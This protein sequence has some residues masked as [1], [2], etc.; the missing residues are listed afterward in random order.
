MRGSADSSRG[1]AGAVGGTARPVE[2]QS[3]ECWFPEAFF[4]R[5]GRLLGP[6]AD[7]FL[8]AL[9]APP[10]G[11]RVNTLRLSPDRFLAL[12]PF[13]LAP[14]PFPPEGFEVLGGPRPGRHPYHAA[15][16]YYLQDPSAMAVAALV[17]PQPGEWI[18]DLAAAPGGK[19]THLAARLSGEGVLVANDVHRGRARELAGNL[20]RFGVRNAVVTA[21]RTERLVEYFGAVFD[22]VL[23]DAPCSGEAMFSKSEAAR[24]E[25]SP[26]AIAGCAR[27]QLDLLH[28]AAALVWPG[29]RLVYATCTFAPEE[30]EEVIARFLDADPDF[31]LEA[32]DGIPGAMPG[33]PDWVRS[34]LR[35]EDLTKAVRLWP[36]RF[37][38]AGHFIAGLR[39]VGGAGS[40]RGRDRRGGAGRA[41]P[42]PGREQLSLLEAYA[43]ETLAADEGAGSWVERLGPD[44]LVTLGPE[45][46][47]L[48]EGVSFPAGL[49][50]VRP[51]WWLG[52]LRKGRFEPSH[53]LALA[54]RSE[55]VRETIDFAA[56]DPA[57]LISGAR[58]SASRPWV[59]RAGAPAAATGRAGS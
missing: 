30:D 5:V 10:T 53:A 22:R 39:R 40:A 57:L 11:L 51:G 17:D 19:S 41:R 29:G 27:R 23:L 37:P 59:A 16:L 24:A 56:D 21:E 42:A 9:A 28:D 38:G 45:L 36:H 25:W 6:E 31:E 32:L 2:E 1:E 14:L 4:E 3:G 13:E 49:R 58:R 34:E 20:E 43:R 47:R 52:T 55:E 18:L 46:Y 35:L 15:G 12:S 26:A 33:R 54:I 8:A 44:R 50:L 48:P 7:A